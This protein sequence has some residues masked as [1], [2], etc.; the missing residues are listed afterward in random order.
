MPSSGN[1]LEWGPGTGVDFFQDTNNLL[2]G[3]SVAPTSGGASNVALGGTALDSLTSGTKNIAVGHTAGTAITSGTGNVLVGSQAGAAITTSDS[4]VAIGGLALF[5]EDTSS[6]L[7]TA[8]GHSALKDQNGGAS[9]TALGYEAGKNVVSGDQ[10]TLIGTQSGDTLTT[11]SDN[12]I[13]G[14]RADTASG[15]SNAI[16][17]GSG[18]TAATQQTVIGVSG[19]SGTLDT[20]IYG[21]RTNVTATTADTT[22]TANDSGE[23]FVF[24]DAAATFTLPDSGAG[25]LTGVYFNFIVLDDT[26]GTKRIQCAD[27][28]NEDLIGSVRSVDT[29]TSDATASFAS[30]V[31]DEFHQITFDG[32]TTGRA[33]SKVTVTNIAADKWHVEGTLLCTG[34]PATPFS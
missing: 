14:Y 30:Q 18:A 8:V 33:G 9:N 17:I 10:N 20:R 1:V 2:V 31:S 25:D 28:T 4:N 12:V 34:N 19:A 29:D 15:A 11:G 27:S 23:T 21:L 24:N 3:H 32:T 13:I 6:G 16:A 5:T 7:N 26:A 22:L